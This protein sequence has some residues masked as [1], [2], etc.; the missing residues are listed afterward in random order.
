MFSLIAL[1]KYKAFNVKSSM[2]T[3][4]IGFIINLDQSG[5][6]DIILLDTNHISFTEDK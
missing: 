3:L 6:F 4:I 2:K 5:M 1:T